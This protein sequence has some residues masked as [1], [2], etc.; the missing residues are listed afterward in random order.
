MLS[1]VERETNKLAERELLENR[2]PW[3][4]CDFPIEISSEC[5]ASSFS[6]S[7][8]NFF[9]SK[10]LCLSDNGWLLLLNGSCSA[11]WDWPEVSPAFSLFH[12][13]LLCQK[14]SFLPFLSGLAFI[15]LL[16]YCHINPVRPDKTEYPL[17]IVFCLQK[18]PRLYISTDIDSKL[19]GITCSSSWFYPVLYQ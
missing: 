3:K 19:I 5:W 17:C 13:K 9:L 15:G 14:A 11:L 7:V 4:C 16:E 10:Y 6:V 12:Y 2:Q 18:W 1:I 8:R